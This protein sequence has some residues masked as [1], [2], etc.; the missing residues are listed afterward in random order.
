M[1]LIL[2]PARCK[3]IFVAL[4]P[5]HSSLPTQRKHVLHL[6]A[7]HITHSVGNERLLYPSLQQ[8]AS[9]Y[10]LQT[11][12]IFVVR[13]Y[14]HTSASRLCFAQIYRVSLSF[15]TSSV[16]TTSCQLLQARISYRARS[17]PADNR[18]CDAEGCFS[19]RLWV[20][21]ALPVSRYA[22]AHCCK[23]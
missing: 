16:M 15:V 12:A 17:F 23:Y 4:H 7:L 2:D 10:R 22:C 9:S 1:K 20:R 3:P 13:A 19:G 18:R 8:K 11:A 6:R 14:R 5:P 21:Q